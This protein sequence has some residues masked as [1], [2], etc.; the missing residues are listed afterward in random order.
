VSVEALTEK[1]ETVIGDARALVTQ[2]QQLESRLS[3]LE[4][5][6]KQLVPR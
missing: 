4:G 3:R 5:S 6:A 2:V 1:I